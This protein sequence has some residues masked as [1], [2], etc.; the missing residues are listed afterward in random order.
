MRGR[1]A[2]SGRQRLLLL[3]LACVL[4]AV[5]APPRASAQ[6]EP[7]PA[8]ETKKIDEYGKIGHCDETARLDNF[9]IELQNN[10]GLSGYLLVYVGKNDLPSWTEGILGRAADYLVNTRGLD[11]GRIKVIDGGYREERTT[12]LWAVPEHAAPPQPSNTV[13]HKLDRTKAYQWDEDAFDVE[14]NPDDTEPAAAEEAEG[15]TDAADN[16]PAEA[17]VVEAES[18]D[19]A[20]WREE[21]E[22]YHIEVVARGV[23]E[24]EP[25]PEKTDTGKAESGEAAA[26]D[27]VRGEEAPAEPEPAPTIGEIK[28]SLWWNVERLAGELKAV[29][30]ARVCLVYYW[31]VQNA[32]QERAK[33]MAERAVAKTAEQLG[34]KRDRI[35]VI[36]GG[37]SYDPGVEL[38]VVPQGAQPPR[39]APA[40]KRKFGFYTMPGEE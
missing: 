18:A 33:E 34:L 20:R 1:I 28:I 2:P 36:D 37:R 6:G 7:P 13:E 19:E 4:A 31:G 14:F 23:I 22:K 25:Q 30:D 9:A 5:A 39:P 38:W 10:P 27:A 8:R 35:L 40:Q 24:D 29:P 11:A 12:E 17:S 15:E 21:F 3:G 16:A 32:T 26:V